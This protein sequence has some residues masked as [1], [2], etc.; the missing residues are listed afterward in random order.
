MVALNYQ[1]GDLPKQVNIG[2]YRE[3]GRK[4]YVLKPA[5]ML[6]NGPGIGSPAPS[7]P[8][9]LS[10]H[11][12]SGQ[13]LPK[14][15]G[16]KSGEIVDPFVN[17]MINGVHEDQKSFRTKVISN[18]GFNPVWDEVKINNQKYSLISCG[19]LLCILS[20]QIFDFPI[21]NPDCAHLTL[22]VNHEYMGEYHEF[23]AYSSIPLSCL[24]PGLRNVA[25]FDKQGTNSGDYEYASLL[26]R[27]KIE[28]I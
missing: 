5:Y 23:L 6:Y 8:V 9:R 15:G 24:R 25:L 1:T 26:V 2:K 16:K 19:L 13:Q 27:I 7:P 14:A 22:V 28:R 11:V 17:V 3:N 12:I 18:N 21:S 20:L 10:V 4:G